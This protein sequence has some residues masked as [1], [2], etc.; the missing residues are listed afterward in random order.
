M[1]LTYMMPFFHRAAESKVCCCPGDLALYALN[2]GDI[3]HHPVS[4]PWFGVRVTQRYTGR[5]AAYSHHG[6][7]QH[8]RL[9][10]QGEIN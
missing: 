10:G 3:F 4:V 8:G 9:C 7:V 6:S 1:F 2:F 5:M